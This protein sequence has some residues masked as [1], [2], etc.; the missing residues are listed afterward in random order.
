[1]SLTMFYHTDYYRIILI[2]YD[3]EGSQHH[4]SFRVY[5]RMWSEPP[6]PPPHTHTHKREPVEKTCVS[7][8][9]KKLRKGENREEI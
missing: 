5:V 9:E 2:A 3:Y 1:M 7:Q 6:P 8:R 4:A